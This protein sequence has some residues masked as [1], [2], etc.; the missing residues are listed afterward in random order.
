MI[1][2][3]KYEIK[4]VLGNRLFIFEVQEPLHIDEP[5]ESN[6]LEDLEELML[7]S[8]KA[9]HYN[10]KMIDNVYPIMSWYLYTDK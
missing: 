1:K 6:V 4:Q 10:R 7:E 9:A 5:N 8:H 2:Q 3:T